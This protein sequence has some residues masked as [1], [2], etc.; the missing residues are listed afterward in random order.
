MRMSSIISCVSNDIDS[1]A[2]LNG[3]DSGVKDSYRASGEVV[4]ITWVWGSYRD[5]EMQ[6]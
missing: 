5:N 3:I 6:R 1:F 2:S 4:K